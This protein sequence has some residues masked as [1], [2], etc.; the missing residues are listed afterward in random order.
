[1]SH[2]YSKLV[3]QWAGLTRVGFVVAIAWTFVGTPAIMAQEAPQ[4]HKVV[5]VKKPRWDYKTADT[6][7]PY[8]Q[9]YITS[10]DSSLHVTDLISGQSTALLGQAPVSS[11]QYGLSPDCRW[12]VIPVLNK[13]IDLTSNGVRSFSGPGVTGKVHFSKKRPIEAYLIFSGERSL[14]VARLDLVSGQFTTVYDT[15]ADDTSRFYRVFSYDL[16]DDA[17]VVH[18]EGSL[19]Y[20]DMVAGTTKNLASGLTLKYFYPVA[21]S[22]SLRKI[23]FTGTTALKTV[24]IP[25]SGPGISDLGSAYTFPNRGRG[26]FYRYFVGFGEA[27]TFELDLQSGERREVVGFPSAFSEYGYTYDSGSTLK[28]P[29]VLN[30]LF[31]ENETGSLVAAYKDQLFIEDRAAGQVR[32]TNVGPRHEQWRNVPLFS[33]AIVN[34]LVTPR[35]F[36]PVRDILL[37]NL[38]QIIRLDVDTSKPDLQWDLRYQRL[39]RSDVARLDYGLSG[40]RSAGLSFLDGDS[41]PTHVVGGDWENTDL[42]KYILVAF[43]LKS[44]TKVTLDQL[45]HKSDLPQNYAWKDMAPLADPVIKNNR[46]LYARWASSQTVWELVSSSLDGADKRV[47]AVLGRSFEQMP[48]AIDLVENSDVVFIRGETLVDW[49]VDLADGRVSVLNRASEKQANMRIYP[50]K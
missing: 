19:V 11:H 49:S 48:V 41:S 43:D 2:L 17:I 30:T 12:V 16:L 31:Y 1:M 22:K 40:I 6:Y 42:A 13:F 45:F 25:T 20:V 15:A 10:A 37:T 39:S 26:T 44:K 14:Q 21:A 33:S 50:G 46:V 38:N 29:E 32:T 27:K 9:Q 35:E 36:S 47:V 18:D 4:C 5:S 8:I 34:T 3:K 28:L 24:S 7:Q 23:A